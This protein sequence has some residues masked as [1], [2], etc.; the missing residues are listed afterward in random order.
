MLYILSTVNNLLSIMMQNP[1][2]NSE[3][4]FHHQ[5]PLDFHAA[6]VGVIC[7]AGNECQA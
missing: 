5:S 6:W 2:L 7:G 1:T 4:P 3:A